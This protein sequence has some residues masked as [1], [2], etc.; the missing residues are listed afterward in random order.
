MQQPGFRQRFT[1]NRKTTVIRGQ[2]AEGDPLTQELETDEVAADGVVENTVETS[3]TYA[4]TGEAITSADQ[5]AGLC[6]VCGDVVTRAR[7]VF[8]SYETHALLC[9]NCREVW[10]SIPYCPSHAQEEFLK[11]LVSFVV[12]AAFVVCSLILLIQIAR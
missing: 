11:R 8:C 9:P 5:V 7:A 2:A 6:G 3:F 1:A 4:R 10:A 12:V